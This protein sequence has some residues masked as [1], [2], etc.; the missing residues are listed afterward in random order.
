MMS[1]FSKTLTD[2]NKYMII[3]LTVPRTPLI[4]AYRSFYSNRYQLY[5]GSFLEENWVGGF[6]SCWYS[7]IGRIGVL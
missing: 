4:Q 7:S 3:G 1:F 6:L 2:N 5:L